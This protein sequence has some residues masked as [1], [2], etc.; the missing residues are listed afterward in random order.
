M[1]MKLLTKKEVLKS[2]ICYDCRKFILKYKSWNEKR[3]PSACLIKSYRC[4]KDKKL[5]F[6]VYKNMVCIWKRI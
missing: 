1:R 6:E 5:L 3:I 4:S 2:N